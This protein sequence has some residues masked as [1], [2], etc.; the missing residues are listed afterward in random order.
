MSMHVF[1]PLSWSSW[2]TCFWVVP[3]IP[4]KAPSFATAST[5]SLLSVYRVPTLI[6]AIAKSYTWEC[7][8]LKDISFYHHW[9]YDCCTWRRVHTFPNPHMTCVRC[10]SGT[11]ERQLKIASLR[12][13]VMSWCL[14]WWWGE[15]LTVPFQAED[16]A[17]RDRFIEDGE[18][19]HLIHD[20]VELVSEDIREAEQHMTVKYSL[21][22]S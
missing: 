5:R 2:A 19:V 11:L 6:P 20:G 21:K 3:G 10:G 14:R 4:W 1:V 13:N 7:Y 8:T 16:A 12:T 15:I 9:V 18:H 22:P 17:E